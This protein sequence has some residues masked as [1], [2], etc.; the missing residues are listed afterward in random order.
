[1]KEWNKLPV[2]K[3]IL[4]PELLGQAN[5]PKPLH[6]INPRTIMGDKLWARQRKVIV[7]ATPY[8]KACG[9]QTTMLDV[10][11]D[12]TIDYPK[13]TMKLN[14]YVPL[15]KFCHQF[16]HSGL[17]A[18]LIA[19][20]SIPKALGID[21]LKHGISICRENN[22]KVFISTFEL[23]NK[24]GVN[25]KDV[26]FWKPAP[27]YKSWEDWRLIFGN[28]VYYGVSKTVWSEKYGY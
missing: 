16:I 20:K 21:I 19:K 11:E 9:K 12:Y 22:V 7:Q 14:S 4:Q 26:K 25:T 1:M 8:C 2:I 23:A 28:K 13:A 3:K 15:C 24:L 5:I 27:S 10:H 6:G 18:V 17:L